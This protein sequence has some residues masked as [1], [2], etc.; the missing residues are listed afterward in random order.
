MPR[1]A[2]KIRG[3]GNQRER[4]PR[5]CANA[6]KSGGGINFPQ[7]ASKTCNCRAARGGCAPPSSA[8]AGDEKPEIQDDEWWNA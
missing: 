1:N 4:V 6:T 2:Q 3:S 5:R 8:R 7:T